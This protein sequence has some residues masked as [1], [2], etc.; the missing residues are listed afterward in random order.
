MWEHVWEDDNDPVFE[1]D[2]CGLKDPHRHNMYSIKKGICK[3]S[4]SQISFASTQ[5]K[6]I[7]MH[8]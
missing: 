2:S 4:Y 1:L 5:L 8:F 3:Y 6:F 7:L